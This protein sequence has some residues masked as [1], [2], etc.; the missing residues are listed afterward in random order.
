MR[1]RPLALHL[2]VATYPAVAMLVIPNASL[3]F[4]RPFDLSEDTEEDLLRAGVRQ[5]ATSA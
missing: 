5:L 3:V 4:G 1:P 2:H